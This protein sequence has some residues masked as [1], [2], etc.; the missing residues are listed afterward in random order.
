MS[1]LEKVLENRMASEAGKK[2]KFIVKESELESWLLKAVGGIFGLTKPAAILK[3]AFLA[4][5]CLLAEPNKRILGG[6]RFDE[7][8][9]ILNAIEEANAC[10]KSSRKTLKVSV[11]RWNVLL[12]GSALSDL[13][14]QGPESNGEIANAVLKLCHARLGAL[15]SGNGKGK[16]NGVA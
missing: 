2:T 11:L 4:A 5:S 1:L 12:L 13:S 7:V 8:Q 9:R 16:G 14:L 6:V 15:F 3:E 10:N